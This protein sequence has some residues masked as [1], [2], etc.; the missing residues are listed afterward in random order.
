MVRRQQL[1]I[2]KQ[3]GRR[4]SSNREKK[5]ASHILLENA[6]ES[7]LITDIWRV[8]YLQGHNGKPTCNPWVLCL[9]FKEDICTYT[10]HA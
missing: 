5:L 6:F 7:K 10:A 3:Q 8:D 4:E 2:N 9:F 1:H